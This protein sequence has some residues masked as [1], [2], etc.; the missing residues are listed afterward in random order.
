MKRMIFFV[1]LISMLA[2]VN[3]SLLFADVARDEEIPGRL[4]MIE[5]TINVRYEDCQETWRELS[6]EVSAGLD[7]LLA[8]KSNAEIEE[9]RF[10]VGSF[11]PLLVVFSPAVTGYSVT[12]FPGSVDGPYTGYVRQA[13]G[14][15]PASYTARGLKFV[16]Q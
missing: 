8:A 11:E 7:D 6:C 5:R 13:F 2:V 4:V 14:R 12:V 3:S 9:V 1:F 16:A 10:N 15:F